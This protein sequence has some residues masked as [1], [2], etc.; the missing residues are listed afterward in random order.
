MNNNYFFQKINSCFKII[1]F[2]IIYYDIVT[3]VV[4]LFR[5]QPIMIIMMIFNISTSRCGVH[6]MLFVGKMAI[7]LDHG[8]KH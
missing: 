4:K 8:H 7:R 5:V 6:L 1:E 3:Q 2:S